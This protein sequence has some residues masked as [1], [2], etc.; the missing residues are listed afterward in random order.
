MDKLVGYEDGGDTAN[1]QLLASIN[2]GRAL[3]GLEPLTTIPGQS[4]M[5]LPDLPPSGFMSG[6]FG[7]GKAKI[8]RDATEAA[9]GMDL[10]SVAALQQA[11]GIE[12]TGT[13]SHEGNLFNI[14]Q[15]TN[16]NFEIV[17]HPH[18][19]QKGKDKT[20]RVYSA[21]EIQRDGTLQPLPDT[22]SAPD[23]E[24]EPLSTQR[25]QEQQAYAEAEAQR[26]AEA[27]AQSYVEAEQA[28]ALAEA[29]QQAAIEAE[30]ETQKTQY[31][32]LMPTAPAAQSGS[33]G[34][35]SGLSAGQLG[36][37]G[38][39]G[40]LDFAGPYSGTRASGGLV[41][42]MYDGGVVGM[43]NGGSTIIV[44]D[45]GNKIEFSPPSWF[46][47]ASDP[48]TPTIKIGN[49]DATVQTKSFYDPDLGGEI[50]V[51]TIRMDEQGNLYIPD[52]PVKEA[53]ER[54]DYILIPGE[55][56]KGTRDFATLVSEELSNMI[57]EARRIQEPKPMYDGGLV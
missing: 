22:D 40:G 54:E 35:G 26:Q 49:K 37:S 42:T 17:S 16:G 8:A 28:K 56:G 5:G 23:F 46:K 11:E 47:R 31:G 3:A 15:L 55:D 25:A 41:Q 45:N 27:E 1:V 50:L 21:R 33:S 39:G 12:G 52:D 34:G 43:K 19:Y 20:A 18:L 2:K 24:T 53:R 9:Y 13:F 4:D 44:K 30:A 7:M 38:A 48:S 36:Q 32:Q 29:Q 14:V 57:N 10:D 51:P 6:L